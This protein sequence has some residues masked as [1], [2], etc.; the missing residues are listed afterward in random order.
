MGNCDFCGSLAVPLIDESELAGAFHNLVS[1]YTEAD[2]FENGEFLAWLIDWDWQVFD[3]DRLPEDKRGELLES[4]LNSDW[5]DDDG[6]PRFSATDLYMRVN[7][8]WFHRTNRDVWQ[9]FC[10]QVR[11]D[12]NVQFPFEDF[13]AD[14]LAVSEDAVIAGTIFHRARPGFLFDENDEREAWSGVDI[15]APPLPRCKAGRANVEG[16]RVLYVADQEKTAVSEVRPAFGS[17][18]SVA[19]ISLRRNA[20]ILDLTR[21]LPQLNPF[22]QDQMVWHREIRALL[23]ALGEEMSRPLERFDDVASYIATQRL[24]D[25]IRL[26]NFDGIRYPSALQP[27]GSSVVFFDPQV[28]EV[29]ESRLVKITFLDLEYEED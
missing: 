10:S 26:S 17:Y 28:G 25:Y 20:R 24:S 1:M 15:A 5:D 22:V 14:E 4:I 21:D 13:M 27:A 3:D 9:D 23:C 11:R 7:D 29:V 16:Q 8:Q 12:Q 2:T 18:V 19:C 6:D